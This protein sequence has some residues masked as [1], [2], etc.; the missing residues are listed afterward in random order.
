MF[1]T[2]DP[3]GWASFDPK[4]HNLNKLG[5]DPLGDATYQYQSST[6]SSVRDFQRCRFFF[7]FVAIATRVMGGIKFFE[8]FW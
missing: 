1:Q 7:L 3:Q 5:R 2:C 8:Q 6:P 4:G